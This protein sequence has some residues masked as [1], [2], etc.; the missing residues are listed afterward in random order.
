MLLFLM[1]LTFPRFKVPVMNVNTTILSGRTHHRGQ[2]R[3]LYKEDDKKLAFVTLRREA[4]LTIVQLL[5][6]NV[7]SVIL[8]CK[9]TE[10]GITHQSD[11]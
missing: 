2:D 9:C 1:T 11:T 5:D 4:R 10:C 7:D 6:G 8:I 3:E